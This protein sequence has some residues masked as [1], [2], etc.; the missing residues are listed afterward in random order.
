MSQRSDR[1]PTCRGERLELVVVPGLFYCDRCH[2]ASPGPTVAVPPAAGEQ[3]GLD[4]T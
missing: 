2:A 1:C 4:L 3:L